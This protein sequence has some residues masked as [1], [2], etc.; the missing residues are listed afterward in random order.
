MVINAWMAF[1][2][3]YNYTRAIGVCSTKGRRPAK[4][5]EDNRQIRDVIIM[6]RV[7]RC[8]KNRNGRKSK[9]F[10]HRKRH[11]EIVNTMTIISE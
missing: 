3:S 10:L 8:Q 9:P 6:C 11:G 1:F 4:R 5:I 7:L 2:L